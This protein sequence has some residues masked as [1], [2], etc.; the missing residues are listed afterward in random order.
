MPWDIDKAVGYLQKHAQTH[1]LGH[2]AQYAREAIEAGGVIL[3]R[4]NSAKDYG[5]SLVKVGFQGHSPL[6]VVKFLKGDVVIIQGFKNHPHGHMAM[7]DGSQWISDFK[8]RT[9]YPGPA[10]RKSKPSYKIYRYGILWD[11]S[12]TA[13][14]I[15]ALA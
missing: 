6:N 2:C 12:K 15:T 3:E 1:S 11:K 10:Y 14:Q 8:Q 4:H 13:D 9:L 7:Y 5:S